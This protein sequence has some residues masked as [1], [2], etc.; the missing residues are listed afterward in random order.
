VPCVTSLVAKKEFPVTWDQQ[1]CC[2]LGLT[3][4][5][6]FPTCAGLASRFVFGYSYDVAAVIC[7]CILPSFC[8]YLLLI[9]I[10]CCFFQI[11][12]VSTDDCTCRVGTDLPNDCRDRC[13][14]V[15][16]SQITV[17][18]IGE[19]LTSSIDSIS[20]CILSGINAAVWSWC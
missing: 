5:L 14:A 13:Q 1:T 10:N 9:N 8:Q 7:L 20:K 11:S 4:S 3:Y 18:S 6:Q 16:I 17:Q 15:M 2:N 19:Q 12:P